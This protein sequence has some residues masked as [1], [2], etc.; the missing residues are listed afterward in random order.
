MSK[1]VILG[2]FGHFDFLDFWEKVDFWLDDD[3]KVVD[4]NL[5]TIKVDKRCFGSIGSQSV[6]ATRNSKYLMELTGEI[7]VIEFAINAIQTTRM[8][9]TAWTTNQL[10]SDKP[11]PWCPSPLTFNVWDPETAYQSPRHQ[12]KKMNACSICIGVICP[13][14]ILSIP[15]FNSSIFDLT[16]SQL[17]TGALS[18]TF[19]RVISPLIFPKSLI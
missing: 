6:D 10:R 8:T 17:F 1:S 2:I 4:L 12:Q 16:C 5:I 11:A 14:D 9:N 15:D 13:T 3:W 18:G 7:T 19:E